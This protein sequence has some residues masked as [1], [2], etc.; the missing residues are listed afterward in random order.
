MSASIIPFTGKW[1]GRFVPQP[2]EGRAQARA[3]HDARLI[4]GAKQDN[5]DWTARIILAWLETLDRKQLELIEFRLLGANLDGVSALQALAVVQ[6]FT[7]HHHRQRVS[8]FIS[9]L[10]SGQ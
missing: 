7:D 3:Q 5:D 10:P 4:R 8:D 6:L 1:H 9:K 2:Y